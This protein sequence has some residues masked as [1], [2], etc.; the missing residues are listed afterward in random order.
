MATTQRALTILG[1][2]VLAGATAAGA[3]AAGAGTA[4]AAGNSGSASV[5]ATLAG[6]KLKAASEITR[7]VHDL[8]AAVAAAESATGLGGGQAALVSYLGADVQPLTQ[9]NQK[10]Q[11][12]TTVHQAAQDFTTI[13]T[14]FRVYALVLPAG[15][16]AGDAD[17]AT[18]AAIPALTAAAA[19]AQQHV[20]P[21]NQAVLQPLIDDL[22]A[23]I[24]TASGAANGLAA[25]V[26]ADTPAQWNADHGLLT[27]ARAADQSTDAALRKGREDVRDIRSALRGPSSSGAG[28]T[29][30]TA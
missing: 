7:R 8:D 1:A 19:V 15:R 9:L 14:G 23:Q 29:A 2:A 24:A 11:G 4:G 5:P 10:I 12:E 27:S 30:S 28:V 20:N 16:I 13:F 22:R 25:T 18:A 3:V 21:G 26:L 17:R 6:I